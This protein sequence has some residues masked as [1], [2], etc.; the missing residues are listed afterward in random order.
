MNWLLSNDRIIPRNEA[1]I[2]YLDRGYVFG[3]GIY[4]VFRVYKGRMFESEL[5]YKRLERSLREIK[6]QM[7]YPIEQLDRYLMQ[8]IEKEQLSE[9][10]VYLQITRGA[11]PRTHA[12]P[13][14]NEPVLI[15][16]CSPLARPL[17]SMS[18]GISVITTPD[19]RWLRCD[20]KTLN[21]LPNIL[22]KQTAIE[23]GVDDVIFHREETVT[24]SSS[25]NVFAVR[26]G[27]I[28]TH[29][30]NNLIL[31]GIT[32]LVIRDLADELRIPF[33]EE[34][35]L[36]Q[37]LVSADEV[38]I[39]STTSEVTP[40]ITIDGSQVHNGQPGP[41]VRKLQ[42]AFEARIQLL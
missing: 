40:V 20:I 15:S 36:L 8:M 25:S 3:D 21:L 37:D 32:R 35:F 5:H 27:A 12:F 33:I 31:H 7:P 1:S 19:I 22:A 39:A 6:L 17:E 14:R 26:N 16:Y 24:E 2:S 4:E 18:R 11:A 23:Q 41:M 30:A 28:Y 42:Q 13:T 34:A 10:T 38:F 29:P 9:G